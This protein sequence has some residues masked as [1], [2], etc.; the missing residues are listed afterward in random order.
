MVNIVTS[1]TAC[2]QMNETETE[3]KYKKEECYF[4]T[5]HNC[6]SKSTR[7]LNYWYCS[8]RAPSGSNIGKIWA[9]MNWPAYYRSKNAPHSTPTATKN[10]KLCNLMNSVQ[11][12]ILADTNKL[13]RKMSYKVHSAFRW[14]SIRHGPAMEWMQTMN[15]FIDWTDLILNYLKI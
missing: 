4:K 3:V 15:Q 7:K 8:V 10:I 1:I 14:K 9:K 12:A 6:D 11:F 13:H 5:S 2:D